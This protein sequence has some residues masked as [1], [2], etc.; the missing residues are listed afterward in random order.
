M[1]KKRFGTVA[2]FLGAM[3]LNGC[4]G[5]EIESTPMSADTTVN[6]TQVGATESSEF[7]GFEAGTA[8]PT[9]RNTPEPMDGPTVLVRPPMQT[10]TSNN[11]TNR[12]SDAVEPDAEGVIPVETDGADD[13]VVGSNNT[14]VG[15]IEPEPVGNP[16]C[17]QLGY[18]SFGESPAVCSEWAGTG[19][20]FDLSAESLTHYGDQVPLCCYGGQVLFIVN[21]APRCGFRPQYEDLQALQNQYADRGFTV[22]GF[23]SNDFG[24]QGGSRSEVEQCRVEFALTFEQFMHLG[25]T[26]RSSVGQHPIFAWL[27]SQEGLEGPVDWNFSKFLIARDG[28]LVARW[29][30][31]QNPTDRD[32][33]RAIETALAQ[34]D[35]LND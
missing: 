21:T 8:L 20:L 7:E 33:I 3:I 11:D 35:P 4:G 9:E 24:N 34:E 16:V 2:F 22:L 31:N 14:T 6:L 26:Q 5:D 1:Q 25:V 27:T 32:V 18:Q 17:D 13:E 19:H 29:S 15:E 10:E 12:P 28:R 30:S 23:L